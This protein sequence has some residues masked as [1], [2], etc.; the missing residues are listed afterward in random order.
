MN[1]YLDSCPKN[2]THKSNTSVESL[3]DAMN[4]FFEMKNLD[5]IKDA[6][7]LTIYADEAENSS[8]RETFAIFLI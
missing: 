6:Q 2:V 7:F 5:D 3:L 8:H 4:A 1:Q